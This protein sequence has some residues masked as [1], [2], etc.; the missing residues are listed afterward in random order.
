MKG[1]KEG[2][3][4]K[5]PSLS[6]RSRT[7]TRLCSNAPTNCKKHI[8]RKKDGKLEILV[9]LE[10]SS[11][12]R[13]NMFQNRV[14]LSPLQSYQYLLRMKN[15]QNIQR[16]IKAFC[17]PCHVNTLIK[18]IIRSLMQTTKNFYNNE[19]NAFTQCQSWQ[20]PSLA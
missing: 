5:D 18:K 4:R 2:T 16:V 1:R 15:S 12:T 7:Q 11:F 13:T 20:S 6:Q 3:K 9:S 10:K 14:C 17:Q 8:K 19:K